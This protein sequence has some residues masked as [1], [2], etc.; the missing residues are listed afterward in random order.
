MVIAA[1]VI[2]VHTPAHHHVYNTCAPADHPSIGTKISISVAHGDLH[3]V[4]ASNEGED[5][6]MVTTT[7]TTMMM[8]MT[9]LVMMMTTM[10][11]MMMV[12]S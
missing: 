3:V 2:Y 11:I 1:V 12:V 10:M 7:T 8:M 6:R 9:V 4:N 5:F